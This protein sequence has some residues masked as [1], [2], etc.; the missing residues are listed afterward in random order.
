MLLPHL[1]L[2]VLHK[3]IPIK[4]H[5]YHKRKKDKKICISLYFLDEN[6][7]VPPSF[8]PFF[9]S[10]VLKATWILSLIKQKVK[11]GK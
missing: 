4:K 6:F 5:F 8:L 10:F 9:L 7:S 11:A 2:L 3:R 1:E